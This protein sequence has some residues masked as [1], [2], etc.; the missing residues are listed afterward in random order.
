MHLKV[1]SVTD[2]F[3][4]DEELGPELDVPELSSSGT[5]SCWRPHL[6]FS[7]EIAMISFAL[8]RN[9]RL[10]AE[11]GMR[12]VPLGWAGELEGEHI[13]LVE[14]HEGLTVDLLRAEVLL[15]GAHVEAVE[16]RTDIWG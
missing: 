1:S 14:V 10:D 15:V 3:E 12:D 16:K 5:P 8:H 9:Q 7:C 13:G 4:V 11:G 6:A 2:L